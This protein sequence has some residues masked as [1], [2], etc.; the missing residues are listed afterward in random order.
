MVHAAKMPDIFKHS[1]ELRDLINSPRR[2]FALR[3]DAH[4][5]SQLCSAL[6]V[7]EDTEMAILAYLQAQHEN[8]S[9]GERYLRIYGILQVLLV[10]QDAVRDIAHS[11]SID[12]KPDKDLGAIRG[13]RDDAIGHPTRRRGR[14]GMA[15]NHIVQITMA[16]DGFDLH[17]FHPP[18]D[19]EHSRVSLISLIEKQ[20]TLLAGGMQRFVEVKMTRESEHRQRFRSNPL[21]EVLPN[22]LDYYLG[23][24]SEVLDDARFFSMGPSLI[25]DV[26]GAINIFQQRLV[27]RD[28]LPAN[29]DAFDYHVMPA[30]H[31]LDKLDEFFSEPTSEF[32]K[33][34]DAE[35]FLRELKH[36]INDLKVLAREIDESYSTEPQ[37]RTR[38]SDPCL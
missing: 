17:T 24:I 36:E 19:F 38:Q 10:Q 5:F 9:T 2:H 27:E 22:S 15:F 20:R 30:R 21:V 7:V 1:Q 31:A 25:A 8:T 33:K 34:L 13:V 37:A 11:L 18:G 35:I 32:P 4:V 26:R 23:K 6:D 14:S 12:Y 28:E 29:H 16:W 3:Q